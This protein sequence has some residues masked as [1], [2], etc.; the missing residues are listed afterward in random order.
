M[1]II[2]WGSI[3]Q[4]DRRTDGR[5]ERYGKVSENI[6]QTFV[7]KATEMPDPV[8]DFDSVV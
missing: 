8:L 4:T 7:E 2:F 5:T 6:L 1:L 3:M